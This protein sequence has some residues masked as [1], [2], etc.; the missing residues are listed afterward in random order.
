MLLLAAL[1]RGPR[2]D[3]TLARRTG[4][5][6]SEVQQLVERALAWGWLDESRRL[7]NHGLSQLVKA[8]SWQQAKYAP[9]EEDDQ[10]YYP[11]SLRAP[12]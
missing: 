1:R 12:S 5:T 3:E 8:R 4:L 7:T 9:F 10:Y 11:K 2:F 6:V